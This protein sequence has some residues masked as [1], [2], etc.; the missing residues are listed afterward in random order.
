MNPNNRISSGRLGLDLIY[1]HLCRP[2]TGERLRS[3]GKPRQGL[4]ACQRQCLL[5]P[6]WSSAGEGGASAPGALGRREGLRWVRGNVAN[7][8]VGT[9][10]AQRHQ[11]VAVRDEMARRRHS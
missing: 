2:I 11:R 4:L 6:W 8:A 9:T 1:L 5:S 3:N 10:L 7:A